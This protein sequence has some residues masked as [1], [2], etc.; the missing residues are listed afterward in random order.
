MSLT[1]RGIQVDPPTRTISWTLALLILESRRTFLTG[2]KVPRKRSWQS[3]GGGGKGPLAC[4]AQ[5]AESTRV[6]RQVLL[7]LVLELL[8]EVVDKTVIKVFSTQVSVTGGGL[9]IENTL[10]DS[11]ERHIECSSA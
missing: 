9:D 4:Y 6:R 3:S 8:D 7:V 1:I 10:F 11:Q 5:T 2:S